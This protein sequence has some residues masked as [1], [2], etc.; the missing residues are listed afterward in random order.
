MNR[1]IEKILPFDFT[2][3]HMAGAKMGL[4]DYISR[5]PSPI[6]PL[7]QGSY[8]EELYGISA[9]QELNKLPF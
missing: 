8:T 2:I 3:E 7:S 1:W 5:H 4:T 9:I 6:P